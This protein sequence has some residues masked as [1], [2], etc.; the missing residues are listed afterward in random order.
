MNVSS[1]SLGTQPSFNGLWG[2]REYSHTESLYGNEYDCEYYEQI[3]HPCIDEDDF[4]IKTKLENQERILNALEV[5]NAAH[6]NHG[7]YVSTKRGERLN[8][9]KAELEEIQDDCI[10]II[11]EE[12]PTG[13][14]I[15]ILS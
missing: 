9:T 11:N 3:Y 5:D 4:E 8:F 13:K 2:K 15:N 10:R 6:C 12:M 1:V 7:S 14:L